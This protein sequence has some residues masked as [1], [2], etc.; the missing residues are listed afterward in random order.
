[1]PEKNV[2][3]NFKDTYWL[4]IISLLKAKVPWELIA[5]ASDDEMMQ[6]LA[7]VQAMTEYEQEVQDR[8]M[9]Q[10]RM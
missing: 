1:V 5:S 7:T 4:T 9:N 3:N 2:A 10:Q 6:I 8:S